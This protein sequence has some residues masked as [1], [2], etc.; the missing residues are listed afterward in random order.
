NLHR[1]IIDAIC[2]SSGYRKRIIESLDEKF[3]G[4]MEL[5]VE[6]LLT[7]QSVDHRDYRRH[8]FRVVLSM[9]QLGGVV[10]TGRGGSFILGPRRGFHIRF[11]AP[12]QT[13]IANLMKFTGVT[14]K[15]AAAR[16]KASDTERKEL[17][18]RLFDADNDDS[19]HYDMVVNT[20]FVDVEDLLETTVTLIDKKF[21]RLAE[22]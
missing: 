12:V 16:I 11:I 19:R 7:G 14:E 15:E 8:L 17:V 6:S 10:L 22:G 2:Q 21:A 20:A 5:L 1:E 4:Q 13:R 9:S 18:S 3:R